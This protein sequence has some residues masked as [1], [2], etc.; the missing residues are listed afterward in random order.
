MSYEW[1]SFARIII[2]AT[3]LA[4]LIY[5]AIRKNIVISRA[6]SIALFFTLTFALFEINDY[7][8]IAFIVIVY[9]LTFLFRKT[10]NY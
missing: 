6:V 8:I 1:P 9:C 3:L 4:P 7:I 10:L 2:L 5:G